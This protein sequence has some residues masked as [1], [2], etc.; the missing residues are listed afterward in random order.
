MW[1]LAP[2]SWFGL[3]LRHH[4]SSFISFIH[5]LQSIASVPFNLRAWQSFCTT[6]LQVLFGL[7]LGLSSFSITATACI[8]TTRVSQTRGLPESATLLPHSNR[9]F[10]TWATE[11]SGYVVHT[12]CLA[13]ALS[14]ASLMMT[15]LRS[16]SFLGGPRGALITNLQLHFNSTEHIYR[17]VHIKWSQLQFCW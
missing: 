13:T 3:V 15:W 8:S 10:V 11:T 17:V 4:Q 9:R 7:P 6:S 14:L 16:L 5:L 12:W 2:A 1:P